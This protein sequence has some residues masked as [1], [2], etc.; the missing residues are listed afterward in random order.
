M[1]AGFVF[2]VLTPLLPLLLALLIG[3]LRLAR[4][5]LEGL[6]R[7]QVVRE[8]RA[9]QRPVH[10]SA[11]CSPGRELAPHVREAAGRN[12]GVFRVADVDQGRLAAHQRNG[13]GVDLPF[14]LR[15]DL[16]AARRH[17]QHRGRE[18]VLG[19]GRRRTAHA[20]M[21]ALVGPVPAN[22]DQDVGT[23]LQVDAVG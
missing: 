7:I 19:P 2:V 17:P 1:V 14:D 13:R 6:R 22:G 16:I 18:R 10:G 23:A 3:L 21:P 8:E 11:T 12:G 15:H 4:G 20:N 9:A 5:L